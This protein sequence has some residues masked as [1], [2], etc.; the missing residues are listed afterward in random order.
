MS[1]TNKSIFYNLMKLSLTIVLI[2]AVLMSTINIFLSDRYAKNE[3]TAQLKDVAN[4]VSIL[5]A[6]YTQRYSDDLSYL[7]K[8]SLDQLADYVD[9]TVIIVDSKGEVFATSTTK[10]EIPKNIDISSYGDVFRGNSIGRTGEFN[11]IFK[12]NTFSVAS[13]FEYGGRISGIIFVVV[14]NSFLSPQTLKVSSMTVVSVAIAIIIALLTSYILSR[15]LIRPLK[16][17][18]AAAREIS[19]GRYPHIETTTKINEYSEMINS[20]NTMSYKLEKQ[21]KARAD[22]IANVSHDLRTPLTAVMGYVGGVIDGTIPAEMQNQYLGVA[23]SEAKRMRDMVNNNLDLSKYESGNIKLNFS[24]F[25]LNDIIRSI[26]VSME[27]RIREKGI[28]VQFKYQKAENQ[29]EADESAIYRVVQN[30]LDNALKFAARDTEIEITITCKDNTTFCRIKNYGSTI[31][32]EEQ[33]FIWDRYFKTDESRG[34][35]RRGSGLGLY[36]VKNIINQHNHQVY[37]ES[38]ENSVAFEFTLT[39]SEC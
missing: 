17:M 32:E 14:R 3:R 29:V 5:T 19:L 38:D 30:L 31:S 25:N 15:R 2:C 27:S 26:V 28:T 37:I 33:K 7:Y 24:V 11:R 21:D 34:V 23:L 1:K 39:S 18:S 20:F 8:V 13:P 35:D 6:Q 12:Y 36:I 10:A 16:D 4:Q 22:F 9:G